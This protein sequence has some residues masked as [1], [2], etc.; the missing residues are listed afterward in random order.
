MND[1]NQIGQMLVGAIVAV[2]FV[3]GA[4]FMRFWRATRDRFFLLF[5]LSFWLEAANRVL[6]GIL[7]LWRE[8][9]PAYYL[10]RLL[11]YALIA[12]AIIDKNRRKD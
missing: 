9:T 3:I 11:S 2:S 10:V 12:G 7:P 8:D 5:A 1:Y 6:L 4:F